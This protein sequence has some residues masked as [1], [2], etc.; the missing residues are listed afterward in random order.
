MY[1]PHGYVNLITTAKSKA[2]FIT[3]IPAH[4]YETSLDTN[5]TN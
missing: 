5:K 3:Q 2:F 4:K 1:K